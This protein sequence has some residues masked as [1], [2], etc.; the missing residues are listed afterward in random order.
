MARACGL[1]ALAFF[2]IAAYT[3]WQAAAAPIA[4]AALV[5]WAGAAAC[6]F[7]GAEFAALAVLCAGEGS[8]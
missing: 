5:G 3:G 6:A 4:S 1:V 8:A 7:V 2:G